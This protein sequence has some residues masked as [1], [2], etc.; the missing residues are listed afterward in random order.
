MRRRTSRPLAA[1][2]WIPIACASAML[3]TAGC[4]TTVT[5]S[6]SVG[7]P[8][9]KSPHA[10]VDQSLDDMF[11]VDTCPSRLQD[12]S[13]ALLTYYAG[14]GELPATLQELMSA[15]PSQ[16]LQFTC[17]V[18]GRRY[19]YFRRGL[20]SQADART[21][22]AAD[23]TPVHAGKRWVVLFDAPRGKRGPDTTVIELTESMFEA[24]SPPPV[25]ASQPAAPVPAG[26]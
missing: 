19:L 21:L 16:P 13:G 9:P 23:A 1:S 24:Y 5:K 26:Q 3:I 7:A 14:H 11:G 18:S 20:R 4:Q 17:P 25:T 6:P 10:A 8:L 12:I 2:R 15:S 22:V